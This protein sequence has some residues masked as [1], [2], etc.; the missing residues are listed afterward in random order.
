MTR[1]NSTVDAIAQR[2]HP[3]NR[4]E[5]LSCSLISSAI[6]AEHVLVSRHRPAPTARALA[7][8]GLHRA[9]PAGNK[10]QN[11]HEPRSP[12]SSC[13]VEV[14]VRHRHRRAR[15]RHDQLPHVVNYD[16]PNVPEDYIPDRPHGR[17]GAAAATPR[18]RRLHSASYIEQLIPSIPP[19]SSPASSPSHAIAADFFPQ[20][21][22]G[23]AADG[24]AV[25]LAPPSRGPVLGPD[26][27]SRATVAPAAVKKQASTRAQPSGATG[28][29]R[30]RV[31][32]KSCVKPERP[33]HLAKHG[34]RQ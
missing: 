14:I 25:A 5:R 7:A 13:E 23:R 10:S 20:R 11:R 29:P 15:H 30:V 32:G 1:A 12:I 22:R 3:V 19:P 16:L 18:V 6:I 31:Q 8:R 9:G 34:K 28:V 26:L 24:R 2:V 4:E 27:R 33:R 21:G 17:A